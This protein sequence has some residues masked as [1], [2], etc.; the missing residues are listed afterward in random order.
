MAIYRKADED[1]R[2]GVTA[3]MA[4]YH[5]GLHDAEVRIDVLMAHPT[6][7]DNGDPTGPAIRVGGYAAL[8]CIRILSYKDRIARNYDAELLVDS[9][10]WDESSA[11]ERGALLDHEL[12]HLELVTDADGNVRRDDADR[13][14]LRMRKHDRQFGWFDIVADRHHGDSVEVQQAREML[15][16][17]QFKQCYLFDL[18]EAVL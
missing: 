7:D 9:D 16:S 18:E 6:S 14:K 2:E 17:P 11:E 10:H 8:A 15:A 4:L 5:G 13:P 3:V 1:V 12:T